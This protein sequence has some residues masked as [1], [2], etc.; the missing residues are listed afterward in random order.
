MSKHTFTDA[1]AAHAL[2]VVLKLMKERRFF[3]YQHDSRSL[4]KN[5]GYTLDPQ[6]FG[7]ALEFDRKI[8]DVYAT[9]RTSAEKSIL[10]AEHEL[11]V[12]KPDLGGNKQLVQCNRYTGGLDILQVYPL[13]AFAQYVPESFGALSRQCLEQLLQGKTED[14]LAPKEM[15]M[16]RDRAQR[17]SERIWKEFHAMGAQEPK[18]LRCVVMMETRFDCGGGDENH[19]F[20]QGRTRDIQEFP[21]ALGYLFYMYSM[22]NRIVRHNYV[23]FSTSRTSHVRVEHWSSEKKPSI[24]Y[25]ANA[26]YACSVIF[27]TVF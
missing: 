3:L 4:E 15:R 6:V 18:N 22:Q 11:G 16:C 8:R 7:P 25:G 14:D 5:P 13:T 9:E 23:V 12:T 10:A 2:E 27:M 24:Y 17:T 20:M 19:D 21:H 26:G 1:Q